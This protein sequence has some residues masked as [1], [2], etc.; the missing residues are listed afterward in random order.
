MSDAPVTHLY[1]FIVAILAY[2][3]KGITGFGNTLVLSPLFS[4]AASNRLITPVDLVL[5]FPANVYMAYRERKHIS[6]KI[7]LPLSLMLAAGIVP[8]VFFLKTGN[9]WVLKS[10]LGIV[11]VAMAV[12]MALRKPEGPEKRK[13]NPVLLAAIG[14]ASGVLCGLFGIGA[15]LVAY[16]S[17]TTDSMG[18]FRANLCAVFVVENVFRLV[19]YSLTGILTAEALLL[20]LFLLPASAIGLFI[21]IK[22]NAR[23]KPE[24][25]KKTVLA[26]LA[27]SGIALFITNAI[28]H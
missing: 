22:V 13:A 16:I 20:S 14:V 15:L 8:G 4:F 11:V 27:V 12:E 23:L 21:G 19:I 1:F 18:A 3:F 5:G 28:F 6:M 26:L 2:F 9:D 10:I 25:A 7:V 24:T 17:R